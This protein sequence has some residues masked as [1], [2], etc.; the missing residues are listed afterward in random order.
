MESL[1]EII[2]G[3][4][5][6]YT[7]GEMEVVARGR[8]FFEE[9]SNNLADP[10]ENASEAGVVCAASGGS[11]SGPEVKATA[12]SVEGG[13]L[14]TGLGIALV[15]ADV[16]T[17]L[18]F[19]FTGGTDG[20]RN[21]RK[22]AVMKK[23]NDH[24]HLRFATGGIGT[25]SNASSEFFCRGVWEFRGGEQ[26]GTALLA[27]EDAQEGTG[28]EILPFLAGNVIASLQSA[29]LFEPL[30]S[31]GLVPQTKV[32]AVAKVR[33]KGNLSTGVALDSAIK[34]ASLHLFKLQ[35]TFDKSAEIDRIRLLSVVPRIERLKA[36]PGGDNFA[37][38]F[39][40]KMGT[41]VRK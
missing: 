35:A 2:R 23:I 31:I 16:A 41:R 4:P 37:S 40:E 29:F 14:L 21:G 30:E 13:T 39:E 17:C 38:L 20:E 1:A 32:T 5:Q 36:V 26:D 24:S 18:A 28:Q 19:V 27:Y 22:G 9:L 3:Q 6:E 11:A 25:Q 7:P 15:D 8:E 33:L 10:S 12:A 34:K